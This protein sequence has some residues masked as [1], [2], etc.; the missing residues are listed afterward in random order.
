MRKKKKIKQLNWDLI[1]NKMV[2][3]V[4]SVLQKKWQTPIILDIYEFRKI[5][6]VKESCDGLFTCFIQDGELYIDHIVL[7]KQSKEKTLYSL[8][9]ELGHILDFIN[10]KLNELLRAKNISYGVR[11]KR[12]RRIL[13]EREKRACSIGFDLLQQAGLSVSYLERYLVWRQI[14]LSYI[15]VSIKQKKRRKK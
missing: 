6:W 12:N 7:K 9:H 14:L 13:F 11:D 10:F 2:K 8:A 5:P 15:A 4:T 3:H 1:R